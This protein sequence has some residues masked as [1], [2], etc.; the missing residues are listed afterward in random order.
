MATY[1][2]RALAGLLIGIGC[3]LP[4]VSGGVMAVSFGLYKPMLDAT[5]GFFSDPRRHTRFL[6]PL[7]LGGGV[8]F[9]LG[10]AALGF[11]MERYSAELL[12]LFI[13][14]ILGGAGRVVRRANEGGFRPRYLLALALGVALALA[15]TLAPGSGAE[16][17]GLNLPQS[18]MA[19]AIQGFS[20]VVPGVSGSFLLI[21]LGW[22]QAYLN[23]IST[24]SISVIA[25]VALGFAVSALVCMRGARWLFD[26]YPAYAQYGVLGFL[27]VSTFLIV[28]PFGA[29]AALIARAI[30]LALGIP[31]ALWMNRLDL[32]EA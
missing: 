6:L 32:T 26:R 29:G 23:A 10:A 7:A 28:P 25:P 22:Y 19:G 16:V 15:L 2:R 20:T 14:F 30:C 8:G 13:G 9:Y 24:L 21:Y 18:L 5:L 31:G 4:G 11:L 27:L 12:F 1:M 17:E 3:V